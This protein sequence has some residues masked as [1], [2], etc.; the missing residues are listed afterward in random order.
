MRRMIIFISTFI[1]TILT[2]CFSNQNFSGPPQ[3][4][5]KKPIIY[6]MPT[7]LNEISGITF[8]N[9]RKDLIYAVQDESGRFY[10]YEFEN[11]ETKEV[12][13]GKRGDYEDLAMSDD[14]VVVLESNGT[15]HTFSLDDVNDH[16]EPTVQE[17]KDLVPKGEYEGLYI[18][19]KKDNLYVLCKNCSGDKAAN[20]TTGYILNMGSDGII[21]QKGQFSINVEDIEKMAKVKKINFQPSGLAKNPMTDEWYIISSANNAL[22]VTDA[23][24]KVIAVYPLPTSSFRQP[25][26]IAFDNDGNLYIS[27]EKATGSS[28]N[29]LK[30]LY[31]KTQ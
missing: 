1:F 29:I 9:N 11:K 16:K 7:D 22:V 5:F 12:K 4:N 3:Y 8:S 26:G 27:N 23:A 28:G 19:N 15:L 6:E 31:T 24:W 10:D 18:D 13:F 14:L 17:L 21:S 2:A 25:E 20:K 30:F